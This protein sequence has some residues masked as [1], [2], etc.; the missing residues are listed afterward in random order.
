MELELEDIVYEDLGIAFRLG[1]E[2]LDGLINGTSYTQVTFKKMLNS[3]LI[4]FKNLGKYLS[5]DQSKRTKMERIVKHGI[6]RLVNY[7]DE[8][9]EIK[10]KG[11]DIEDTFNELNYL[12]NNVSEQWDRI[13]SSLLEALDSRLSLSDIRD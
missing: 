12:F 5:H 11:W 2:Y 10:N 6:D 3:S 13:F 9:K 1:D 4:K 7:I 8:V